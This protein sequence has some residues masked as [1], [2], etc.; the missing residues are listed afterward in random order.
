ML[1]WLAERAGGGMKPFTRVAVLAMAL[2]WQCSA[3]FAQHG[4]GPT[5]WQRVLRMPAISG[6]EQTLSEEIRKRLRE[7]SPKTDNLGN[8]YISVGSGAPH[9]LVVTPIDEPGYVVSEITEQGYLRVQRLP[10]R[11]PNDV[12]D[13]LNFAQP[14]TIQT[15][16]GPQITGVFAGLSVHLQSGRLNP[17]KMTSLDELYVD[18]GARS[19]EEVRK[20]GVDLLD[21][22][23]VARPWF[24]VGKSGE[25]GPAVGDRF[26]AYA[27][28]QVLGEMNKSKV[29]GT[30]TLA[31]LTQQW[32]DGRGLNRILEETPPDELI[33]VGRLSSQTPATAKS[34]VGEARPGS[35][36]LLGSSAIPSG[37][38]QTL[39]TEF[40]IIAE[41]EKIPIH[42]VPANEPLIRGYG[43]GA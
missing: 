38:E 39:A 9:R 27:L 28:V 23:V 29:K 7:L 36:I 21:P 17:P 31:F 2:G 19:A 22:L 33:Y 41:K 16:A 43:K 20:A 14:V 5:D 12:F 10:Q 26:G 18:I 8:V 3:A 42:M 11:A 35:G 15:H 34:I 37:T 13:L 6:Y 25:A 40:Q 32:L 30:T 4:S 24:S 1:P